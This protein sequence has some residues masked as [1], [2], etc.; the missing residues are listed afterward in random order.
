MAFGLVEEN[1]QFRGNCLTFPLNCNILLLKE[2]YLQGNKKYTE[3]VYWWP[4]RNNNYSKSNMGTTIIDEAY[5]WQLQ[6]NGVI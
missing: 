6:E 3:K 1:L 2:G 4:K 5:N